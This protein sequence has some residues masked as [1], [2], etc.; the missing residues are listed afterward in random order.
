[1]N[2][3]NRIGINIRKARE[4]SGMSQA[5]LGKMAGMTQAMI[6][7]YEI[8]LRFPDSRQIE[9][10]AHAFNDIV[11]GVLL[12]EEILFVENGVTVSVDKGRLYMHSPAEQH[13]QEKEIFFDYSASDNP[14]NRIRM[15]QKAKDRA[16]S[17]RKK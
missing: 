16:K 13:D 11:T 5:D 10:L 8:G 4:F 17:V 7:R 1:M 3:H 15:L 2:T 9:N 12:S 6:S 14:E